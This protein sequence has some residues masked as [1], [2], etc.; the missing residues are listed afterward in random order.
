MMNDKE[1]GDEYMRA[2]HEG[3]DPDTCAEFFDAGRIAT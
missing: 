3:W 2:I 1:R